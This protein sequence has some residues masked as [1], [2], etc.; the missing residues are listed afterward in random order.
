MKV[1]KEELIGLMTAVRWYLDQD[2]EALI[3]LYEDQVRHAIET[4]GA[5]PHVT[6]RRSFPSEAGQPMP[7]AEITLDESA[8]GLTRDAF[9]A[10]LREGDPSIALSAAGASGVYLNPQTLEPG[11]EEIIVAR[12][13]EILGG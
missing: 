4:L 11:Q 13:A 6:A 8:L 1:G 2:E 3:L 7:R 9:L 12:I 10:Q 5:L